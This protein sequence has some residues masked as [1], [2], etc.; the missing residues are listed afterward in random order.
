VV[1]TTTRLFPSE[2]SSGFVEESPERMRS[3]VRHFAA[4]HGRGDFPESHCNAP[5]VSAVVEADGTVRPC[6]F[7]RALGRLSDG[8]LDQVLNSPEAVR[9]RR[10]L[11]VKSN[12]ICRRCVC[13]LSLGRTTSV[14]PKRAGAPS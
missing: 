1:E 12:P 14:A 10:E 6:F 2:F 13:T 9:F 8:P 4:L 5:W 3:L 11:D 7:H